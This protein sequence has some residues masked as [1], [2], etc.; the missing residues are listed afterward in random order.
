[1]ARVLVGTMIDADGRQV[2]YDEGLA[3]ADRRG[4]PFVE[5]SARENVNVREV[6]TTLL[7]EAER[8][9]MLHDM[10]SYGT[11]W[12]GMGALGIDDCEC[13]AQVPR[14]SPAAGRAAAAAAAAVEAGI[15]AIRRRR[16]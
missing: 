3:W 16:R 4:I 6:F 5:C 2:S 11:V 14:A 1:M 13:M 15:R 10:A 8:D 7:R 9:T 12:G